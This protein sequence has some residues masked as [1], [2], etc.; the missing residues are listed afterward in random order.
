MWNLMFFLYLK[1]WHEGVNTLIGK[2]KKFIS[3]N[4]FKFSIVIW[5]RYESEF[6]FAGWYLCSHIS[7]IY[8]GMNFFLL[9]VFFEVIS[10][11]RRTRRVTLCLVPGSFFF[12]GPLVGKFLF[13]ILNYLC[14]CSPLFLSEVNTTQSPNLAI[15]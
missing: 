5:H 9:N 4:K 7:R 10:E 6:R 8:W 14:L 3:I 13:S 12:S 15:T 11:W 1:V 2:K